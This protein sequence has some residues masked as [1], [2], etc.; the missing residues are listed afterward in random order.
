MLLSTESAALH[1]ME[2]SEFPYKI[3]ETYTEAIYSVK[4]HITKII[5]LNWIHCF[6]D[7]CNFIYF[8]ILN[9]LA[10]IKRRSWDRTTLEATIDWTSCNFR[11]KQRKLLL[12][13]KF[14]IL[15]NNSK[16]LS[17]QINSKRQSHL[18]IFFQMFL[19]FKRN[20]LGNYQLVLS[21]KSKI[22]II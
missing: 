13:V 5:I 2:S 14:L 1:Y 9:D 17:T 16:E 12:C 7:V 3:P 20:H 15:T 21:W 18:Q 19:K 22:T 6:A 4:K 11:S 10:I 8:F